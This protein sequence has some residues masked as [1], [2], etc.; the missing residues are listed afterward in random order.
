MLFAIV[1]LLWQ[2][3]EIRWV[4]HSQSEKGCL[5]AWLRF[6]FGHP[7]IGQY[8]IN[9][10]VSI[11]V[12]LLLLVSI[13]PSRPMRCEPT[14]IRPTST[15]SDR[16]DL[17][18]PLTTTGIIALKR[19]IYLNR[20]RSFSEIFQLNHHTSRQSYSFQTWEKRSSELFIRYLQYAHLSRSKG[21]TGP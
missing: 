3:D 9:Q 2:L 15:L 8:S 10:Y 4:L 12:D 16:S 19:T 14:S 5:H 1:H 6:N 7:G 17:T 18:R 11:S 21:Q 20:F 13:D